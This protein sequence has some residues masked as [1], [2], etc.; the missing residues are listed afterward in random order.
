M[1]MAAKQTERYRSSDSDPAKTVRQEFQSRKQASPTLSAEEVARKQEEAAR[2]RKALAAAESQYTVQPDI[3]SWLKASWA[4]TA[5][6]LAESSL[7]WPQKVVY[8]QP[9]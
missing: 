3:L 9:D 1:H 8:Y 6:Q 7:V 2:K 5:K 4:E